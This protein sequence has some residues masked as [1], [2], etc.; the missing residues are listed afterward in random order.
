MLRD[1]LSTVAEHAEEVDADQNDYDGHDDR[2]Q[3]I[4]P[5]NSHLDLIIIYENH[6]GRYHSLSLSRCH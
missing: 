6:R 3:N 1:Y 2:N 4:D 5:T